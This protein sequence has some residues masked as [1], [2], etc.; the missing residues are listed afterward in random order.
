MGAG[1]RRKLVSRL[2]AF[3]CVYGITL[4]IDGAL[5]KSPQEAWRFVMDKRLLSLIVKKLFV[6]G[7]LKS[8]DYFW[9]VEWQEETQQAHWHLLVDS[10]FV[11]FGVIVAAWSAFRPRSAGP[12]SWKPGT[13]ACRRVTPENYRDLERPAFGS[14]RFSKPLGSPWAGARYATKYLVKTPN[15]GFPEWVLD[16]EGQIPRYGR[17]KGFF[18]NSAAKLEDTAEASDSD[19]S[20]LTACDGTCFPVCDQCRSRR[21]RLTIRDR[22]KTCREKTVLLRVPVYQRANGE[23]VEGRAEFERMF[24]VPYSTVCREFRLTSDEMANAEFSADVAQ[25]LIR[26]ES[27]YGRVEVSANEDDW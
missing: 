19:D 17:S 3:G 20:E 7:F 22:L 11:P 21:P 5:F 14:V 9:V 4:T 26:L 1:L 8:R 25:N 16:Y 2:A 23:Q 15:G 10:R 18:P 12:L 24:F 27:L 13:S 6:L